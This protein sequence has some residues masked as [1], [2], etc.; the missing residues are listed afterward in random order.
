[1]RSFSSRRRFYRVRSGHLPNFQWDMPQPKDPYWKDLADQAI[2]NG[3]DQM[4]DDPGPAPGPDPGDDPEEPEP[5]VSQPYWSYGMFDDI[6]VFTM[7]DN[8]LIAFHETGFFGF[9]LKAYRAFLVHSIDIWSNEGYHFTI[10]LNETPISLTTTDWFALSMWQ[11]SVD[12][13]HGYII[14][15]LSPQTFFYETG[16]HAQT[17]WNQITVGTSGWD[18]GNPAPLANWYGIFALRCQ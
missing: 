13:E 17:G 9:T 16:P 2:A 6:G 11:D 10:D 4:Y 15:S 12:A 3:W 5:P 14:L 18:A 1:M 8:N 7:S